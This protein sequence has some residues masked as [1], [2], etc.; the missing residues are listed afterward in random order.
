MP[1][2]GDI[3][4][5][6]QDP[7]TWSLTNRVPTP[8]DPGGMTPRAAEPALRE[9]AAKLYADTGK[10]APDSERA[11]PYR[12]HEVKLNAAKRKE[13]R[14]RLKDFMRNWKKSDPMEFDPVDGIEELMAGGIMWHEEDGFGSYVNNHM[15]KKDRE[16]F[17]AAADAWGDRVGLWKDGQYDPEAPVRYRDEQQR[18]LEQE[19]LLP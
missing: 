5:T 6:R 12:R 16:A 8:V 10:A 15:S 19:G 1:S 14:A 9:A 4:W 18:R 7:K 2:F 17:V 13:H 11:D 3:I